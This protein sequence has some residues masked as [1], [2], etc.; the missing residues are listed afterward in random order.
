VRLPQETVCRILHCLVAGCSKVGGVGKTP[1]IIGMRL[2]GHEGEPALAFGK[3]LASLH[4]RNPFT[5]SRSTWRSKL[6][7]PASAKW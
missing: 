5:V 2:T 7:C 6:R 4:A 3:Y 1:R